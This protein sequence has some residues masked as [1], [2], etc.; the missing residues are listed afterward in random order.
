[1]ELEAGSSGQGVVVLKNFF[2][3]MRE[4][5]KIIGIKKKQLTFFEHLLYM[6]H[7]NSIRQGYYYAPF[8]DE[9]TVIFQF[10][11]HGVGQPSI[12]LEVKKREQ[13]EG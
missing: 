6:R 7:N 2:L 3:K 8:M 9:K 4:R 10:K 1:M 13:Q 11:T 5:E 12:G